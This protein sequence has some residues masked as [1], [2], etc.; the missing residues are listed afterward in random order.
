ML[1]RALAWM[2]CTTAA[3]RSFGAAVLPVAMVL[4]MR[5][6]SGLQRL[7][8]AL[9]HPRQPA[10]HRR[11]VHPKRRGLHLDRGDASVIGLEDEVDLCSVAVSVV[12]QPG[13][14]VRPGA[15]AGR[16]TTR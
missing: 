5:C 2:S 9:A 10:V 16:D 4:Q 13:I 12:D 11:T 7:L 8:A 14:L 1:S 15:L 6:R 3:S